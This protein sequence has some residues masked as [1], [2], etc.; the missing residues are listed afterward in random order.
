MLK[1]GH[2]LRRAVHLF[3]MVKRR[4]K[5]KLAMLDLD[6][7]ILIERAAQGDF[8]SVTYNQIM[9]KVPLF[10]LFRHPKPRYSRSF[11]PYLFSVLPRRVAS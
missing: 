3:E 10:L 1:L 2:D 9:A 5:S 11:L 8:G 6:S 7:D 4:E